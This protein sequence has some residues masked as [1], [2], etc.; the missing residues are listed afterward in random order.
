MIYGQKKNIGIEKPTKRAVTSVKE[1][2][3]TKME[4]AEA[5]N[6]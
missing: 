4:I 5:E 1:I 2:V 6:V 3:E